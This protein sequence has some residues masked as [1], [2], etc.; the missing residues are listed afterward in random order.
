MTVLVLYTN[1]K[2]ILLS[3]LSIGCNLH[4][5]RRFHQLSPR[6]CGSA[7]EQCYNVELVVNINKEFFSLTQVL[8]GF[9][10]V[11]FLKNITL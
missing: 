1:R 11:I 7:Y 6:S 2:S 10:I 9:T 3:P 8:C 5:H 4:S